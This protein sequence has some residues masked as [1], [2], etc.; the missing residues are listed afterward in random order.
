MR[1][2]VDRAH[3]LIR[4]AAEL[5][6]TEVT[7]HYCGKKIIEATP[8]S[9]SHDRDRP[10][11]LRSNAFTVLSHNSR[12]LS[13]F[14]TAATIGRLIKIAWLKSAEVT[15]FSRRELKNFDCKYKTER[16]ALSRLETGPCVGIRST[17]IFL[18]LA[19]IRQLVTVRS[20]ISAHR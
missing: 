3:D 11:Y 16:H 8:C 18:L 10:A 12:S 1:Y 19:I 4:S 15:R 6:T 2:I 7:S 14:D 13:K 17:R 20:N 5:L 9:A